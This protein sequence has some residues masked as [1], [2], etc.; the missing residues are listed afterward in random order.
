MVLTL[1]LTYTVGP[2]SQQSIFTFLAHLFRGKR[3]TG[4]YVHFLFD[5][6]RKL[7]CRTDLSSYFCLPHMIGACGSANSSELMI[8]IPDSAI[9][10]FGKIFRIKYI[11]LL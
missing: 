5:Y 10:T 1:I 2:V 11:T 8:I 6:V 7:I 9:S 4:Q 3:G